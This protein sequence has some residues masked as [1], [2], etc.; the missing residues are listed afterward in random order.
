MS[1]ETANLFNSAID[2]N[3]LHAEG[4]K[5]ISTTVHGRY[6]RNASWHGELWFV[7]L[8]QLRYDALPFPQLT[9]T[10]QGCLVSAINVEIID[11]VY[12]VTVVGPVGKVN[13]LI[14]PMSL[15]QAILD[16]DLERFE[17]VGKD[18]ICTS[19]SLPGYKEALRLPNDFVT[20]LS[21]VLR[22][23]SVASW[24]RDFGSQGESVA[25]QVVGSLLG[26]QFCG[27]TE[28]VSLGE[29]VWSQDIVIDTLTQMFGT[30]RARGMLEQAVP[31]LNA[32]MTNEEAVR[33]ILHK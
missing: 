10:I 33:L 24:L 4:E 30:V 11:G 2:V 32:G 27:V 15:L 20:K 5:S 6:G 19:W 8:P 18:G 22:L 28:Q 13:R 21:G 9:F 3:R 17:I 29:Q 16:D 14:L 25:P 31:Y 23:K 26:L 7:P 12:R 1:V